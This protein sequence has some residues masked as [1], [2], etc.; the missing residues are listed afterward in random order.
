MKYL[1]FRVL[2]LCSILSVLV[3][4][5]SMGDHAELRA[6]LNDV[7][8]NA[9]SSSELSRLF[10]IAETRKRRRET[11]PEGLL[12]LVS[13]SRALEARRARA[14]K[15]GSYLALAPCQRGLKIERIATS[16]QAMMMILEIFLLQE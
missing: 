1:I 14:L 3:G 11:T 4:C 5:G 16:S 2:G 15:K 6:K 8:K 12:G 7:K 9:T 10:K 13:R